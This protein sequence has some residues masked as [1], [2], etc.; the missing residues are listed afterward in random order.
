MRRGIGIVAIRLILAMSLVILLALP[1]VSASTVLITY[2][3]L[4]KVVVFDTESEKSQEVSLPGGPGRVALSDDRST[5]IIAMTK[6]NSI[7]VFDLKTLKESARV[8]VGRKPLDVLLY[9]GKIY[10]ANSNGK[11][12]VEVD[13]NTKEVTRR[14]DA[15]K[16]PKRIGVLS[17]NG[18]PR[19]IASSRNDL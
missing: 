14:V 3:N 4:D 17:F 7:S 11:E 2:P 1:L 9:N 6:D 5:A 19:L 15:G 18:E 13:L 16:A 10:V 8:N 12:I